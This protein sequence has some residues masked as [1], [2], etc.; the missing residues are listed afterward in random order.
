[1]LLFR[2]NGEY[3]KKYFFKTFFL[4]SQMDIYFCPF[5]ENKIKCLQKK[6]VF[7][8][9]WLFIK[10]TKN[11]MNYDDIIIFNKLSDSISI[12]LKKS[13]FLGFS[14][15][16]WDFWNL[17]KLSENMDTDFTPLPYSITTS[18]VKRCF[19]C[20]KMIHEDTNFTLRA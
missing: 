8:S 17:I 1:M 7:F 10:G 6:I 15:I 4:K 9:F 5:S 2:W 14:G 19:F 12:F 13:Y 18:S 16:F 11:L 20:G 3:D